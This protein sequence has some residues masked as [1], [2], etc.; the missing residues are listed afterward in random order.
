ME[1]GFDL[2]GD[3]LHV[4][5]RIVGPLVGR[6]DLFQNVRAVRLASGDLC[7]IDLVDLF[8]RLV[9]ACPSR[10]RRS[11]SCIAFRIQSDISVGM[12]RSDGPATIRPAFQA[13]G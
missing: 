11:G 1:M 9:V 6:S 8:F 12:G 13:D 4:A 5:S 2:S 7:L 3:R 10:T